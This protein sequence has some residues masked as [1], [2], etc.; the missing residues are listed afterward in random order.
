MAQTRFGVSS[1]LDVEVVGACADYVLKKLLGDEKVPQRLPTL[2]A[3]TMEITSLLLWSSPSELVMAAEVW[4][5]SSNSRLRCKG[6]LLQIF[7]KSLSGASSN[8]RTTN[9]RME[10]GTMQQMCSA[11]KTIYWVSSNFSSSKL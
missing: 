5:H 1:V 4:A 11:V 7:G 9:V 6:R 2:N 3:R 10:R 8:S